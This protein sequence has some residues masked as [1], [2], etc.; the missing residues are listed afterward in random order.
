MPVNVATVLSILIVLAAPPSNVVPV[1]SCKPVLTVNAFEMLAVIVAVPPKL[2]IL[3]LIVILL[4]AN[5]PLAIEPANI[6]FVTV[7]VS[8]VV[9]MVPS[10][11][12]TVNVRVTPVP[13]PD[14]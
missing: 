10:L 14:N 4:L 2:I 8:P 3:P 9:I 1:F 11:F 5:F 7:L 6:V 12:G 13:M